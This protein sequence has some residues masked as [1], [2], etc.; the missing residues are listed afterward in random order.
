MKYIGDFAEDAT[1]YVYFTTSDSAGGAVAPSSVFEAVDV[2]IFK[3]G[4]AAEKAT[5]NGLV[6]T[7]SFNSTTGLHRLVIDTSDN[8]GDAGFWVT[9]FDYTVILDPS[10]ETVDGETVV[11]V[12]GTFSIEN[13]S[14]SLN[15]AARAGL[16]KAFD[17]TGAVLYLTQLSIQSSAASGA[18]D[19]DNSGGAGLNI[20]SSVTDGV[21]IGAGGGGDGIVATGHGAGAGFYIVGGGTGG[22]Q[23]LLIVE[24]L[25]IDTVEVTST[26]T[27]T[28]AVTMPA[29]LTA[30][31][32]GSLSGSVGSV[33]T[34]TGY[35]LAAD[36]SG[37]TIGTVGTLTGHTNQ[38]GDSFAIVTA[39]LAEITD[40]T[41]IPTTPTPNQVLA[42]LYMAE[43]NNNTATA[44]AR[45]VKNNAGSEV[46]TATMSDDGTTFSQGKLGD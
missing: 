29:G 46:L 1:V 8:T 23:G 27:L 39:S 3:D 28:G 34:K 18:I 42:L 22:S 13:R 17:G 32:T 45:S 12:I 36:Q 24:G 5:N 31:I 44:T 38:T 25:S 4:S 43:R 41:D 6:M 14:S 9:G 40:A 35:S 30:D 20:D 2:K 37:V 11:A 33:T 10:D 26:T 15:A 19:I 21:V 7:S 16:E